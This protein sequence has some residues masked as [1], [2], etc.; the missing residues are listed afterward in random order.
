MFRSCDCKFVLVLLLPMHKE[1]LGV[2]LWNLEQLEKFN[3]GLN[4]NNI[5]TLTV[6]T[7][8]G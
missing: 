3:L 2:Y 6:Q 8:C 7:F 1:A 5:Y 4:S